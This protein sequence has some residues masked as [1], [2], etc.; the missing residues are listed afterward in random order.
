MKS[1]T[2]IMGLAMVMVLIVLGL[3]IYIRFAATS[4]SNTAHPTELM[5]K[6]LPV[7]LNDVM[8]QTNIEECGGET[9]R[10][11]LMRCAD[12][13]DHICTNPATCTVASSWIANRLNETLQTWGFSYIYRAYLDDNLASPLFEQAYG[14]CSRNR[15]AEIFSF[16]IGHRV[17]H[18][19]LDLCH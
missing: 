13:T 3:V 10:V 7:V 8:L 14:D 2:E 19:R 4:T 16:R 1:Q 18:M 15:D 5:H 6:Q 9:L 17:L 12:G 11:V